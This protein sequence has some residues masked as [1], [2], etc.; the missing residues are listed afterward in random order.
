MVNCL[1]Y[2]LLSILQ[3]AIITFGN[4]F[5]VIPE[6]IQVI[7]LVPNFRCLRF[8]MLVSDVP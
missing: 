3:V 5:K 2:R 6:A 1:C 8:R 7:D 4:G